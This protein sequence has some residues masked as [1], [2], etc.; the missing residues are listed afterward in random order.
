MWLKRTREG[1]LAADVSSAM[2]QWRTGKRREREKGGGQ[3]NEKKRG[4]EEQKKNGRMKTWGDR[5]GRQDDGAFAKGLRRIARIYLEAGDL[6]AVLVR[7]AH[8][9]VFLVQL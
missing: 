8:V 6:S 5:N 4:G 3:R 1:F 2:L 9:C 7:Q